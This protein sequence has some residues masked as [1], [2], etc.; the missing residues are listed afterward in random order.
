MKLSQQITKHPFAHVNEKRLQ[1]WAEMAAKL[2]ASLS[3]CVEILSAN[4][5]TD[6]RA[7]LDVDMV[8]DEA[9]RLLGREGT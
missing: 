8:V 2:E 7:G 5:T 4:R 1:A 3:D 9:N 6:L